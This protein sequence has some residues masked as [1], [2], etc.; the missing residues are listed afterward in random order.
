MQAVEQSEE[1]QQVIQLEDGSQL[2]LNG[3]E[4]ENS[5]EDDLREMMMGERSQKIMN[6]SKELIMGS[7]VRDLGNTIKEAKNFLN[8]KKGPGLFDENE[9]QQRLSE[10]DEE[11]T[12]HQMSQCVLE[13]EN[14]AQ[15]DGISY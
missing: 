4:G 12:S 13:E 9:S 8:S 7:T 6:K 15:F 3:N 2:I 5:S 11:Y 1:E 14:M 10:L